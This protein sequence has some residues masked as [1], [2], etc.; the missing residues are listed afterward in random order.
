M[1]DQSMDEVDRICF[2]ALCNAADEYWSRCDEDY[3]E[4]EVVVH[5]KDYYDYDTYEEKY[6]EYDEYDE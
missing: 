1:F 3:D 5:G 4:D 2:E 6:D